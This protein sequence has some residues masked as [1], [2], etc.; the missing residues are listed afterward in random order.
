MKVT[1]KVLSIPPYLATRWEEVA[2]LR[3]EGGRLVVTLTDGSRVEVPGLSQPQLEEIFEAH[4]AHAES[5]S[6]EP[7][8]G[9]PFKMMPP[10]GMEMMGSAMQHDPTQASAPDL[11]EEVLSKIAAISQ[12]LGAEMAGGVP[13]AEADCNCFHCQIARTLNGSPAE[14][15]LPE[16][17]VSD[18]ELKFKE[19]DIAPSGDKL[20]TVS[21]PLDSEEQYT[22][23]L[24]EP[25]GCTC[26]K[27]G[28]EHIKAVLN[29]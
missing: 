13:Q 18:E 26:G 4:T 8:M 22:V 25:V 29:S 11:P 15:P 23:F 19:W 12:V 5:G 6:V 14:E 3:M 9:M 24:G 7:T 27:G 16:E 2:S 28:C 21:N 1:S 20:Y 17:E 10:G